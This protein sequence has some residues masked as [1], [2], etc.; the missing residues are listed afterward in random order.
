MKNSIV[1]AA[2]SRCANVGWSEDLA[3]LLDGLE[4]GLVQHVPS[5]NQPASSSSVCNS[6]SARLFMCRTT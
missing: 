4:G 1:L 3:E 5:L 6:G 2:H